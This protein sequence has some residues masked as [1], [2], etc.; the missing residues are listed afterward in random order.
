MDDYLAEFVK[1]CPNLKTSATLDKG[2]QGPELVMLNKRTLQDSRCC[3]GFRDWFG[4]RNGSAP[5]GILELPSISCGQI[6][7]TPEELAGYAKPFVQRIKLTQFSICSGEETFDLND[8][9]ALKEQRWDI[10]VLKNL[11]LS[12]GY[13]ARTLILTN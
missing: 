5:R 9:E 8:L 11:E 4:L 6:F 1:R 2:Q 7:I 12:L 13:L 10:E 3:R